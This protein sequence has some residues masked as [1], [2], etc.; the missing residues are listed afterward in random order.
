MKNKMNKKIMLDALMTILFIALMDYAFTGLVLHELI[1]LA[2]FAFFFFHKLINFKW[3][4]SITKR[5]FDPA[6]KAR[7]KVMYWLDALLL[8]DVV[9]I[10]LSGLFISTEVFPQLFTV[11]DRFLW[12]TIHHIASYGGLIAISVHVGLHWKMIMAAFRKMLRIKKPSIVRTAFVRLMALLFIVAGIKSSFDVG[13]AEKLSL[14]SD[15]ESDNTAIT[16]GTALAGSL[17]AIINTEEDTEPE[18]LKIYGKGNGSGDGDHEDEEHEDDEYEDHEE[19]DDDY[20]YDTQSNQTTSDAQI[21]S[22]Q[23][24]DNAPSLSSYLSKLYCT[25]CSKHCPLSAPQCSVGVGQANTASNDYYDT[26]AIPE[27]QQTYIPSVHITSTA[28]AQTPKVTA[29]PITENAPSLVDYLS[30]LYCTGCG[31]HCPL[32]APQCSLGEQQAEES[33]TEYYVIYAANLDNAATDTTTDNTTD[34]DQDNANLTVDQ[35]TDN[36]FADYLPIMGLYI[37][38]A[39]YTVELIDK[40]K[41]KKKSDTK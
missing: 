16:D 14:K 32:S 22:T 10:T 29:S 5:L 28:S 3:I 26:Y 41:E 21:T 4:K 2:I 30:K 20:Y 31:K 38:G 35:I 6:L 34:S 19:D 37:G 25:G 8:I 24:V 9:L 15:D 36:V 18:T 1:G 27:S 33:A 23:V 39:Y 12:V 17:N 40:A 11:S 7:T 13:M